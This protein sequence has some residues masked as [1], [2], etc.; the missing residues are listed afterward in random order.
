MTPNRAVPAYRRPQAVVALCI[1]VGVVVHL[2]RPAVAAE[3]APLPLAKTVEV[4]DAYVKA[5]ATAVQAANPASQLPFVGRDGIDQNTK[6]LANIGSEVGKVLARLPDARSMPPGDL[7]AFLK[8]QPRPFGLRILPD[9]RCGDNQ[10]RPGAPAKD[11]TRVL[12]TLDAGV[13]SPDGATC[14]G[15]CEAPKELAGRP[16]H[17]GLP[18]LELT[19]A[20][21]STTA[22]V[23][24]H[25]TL[26][27]GVDAAGAF[28]STHNSPELL[29][30]LDVVL[31]TALRGTLGVIDVQT[32]IDGAI[33]GRGRFRGTFRF[34]T[35]GPEVRGSAAPPMAVALTAVADAVIHADATADAALPGIGADVH[36]RWGWRAPETPASTSGLSV[37]LENVRLTVGTFLGKGLA[38]MVQGIHDAVAPIAPVAE[39]LNEPIPGISDVIG[40]T[41][42]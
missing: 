27:L 32:T 38:P 29:V 6:L 8:G 4:F 24:W 26:T 7:P 21:K 22:T 20:D 13:G 36:V 34:D 25:L 3:P 37:S 33:D 31:P 30:G 16:F 5:A 1:V 40:D 39:V 17:V 10:C 23:S 9:A 12:L 19:S 41:T 14:G 28:L 18:G 2:A 11:I 15:P 42:L 35:T